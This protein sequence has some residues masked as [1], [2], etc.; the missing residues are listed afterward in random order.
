M[1][2]VENMSQKSSPELALLEAQLA[3]ESEYLAVTRCA[4]TVVA[5]TKATSSTYS[6][7]G[8]RR[9]RHKRSR[10][11]PP[12]GDGHEPLEKDDV[13]DTLEDDLSAMISECQA[14]EE[15]SRKAL[16]AEMLA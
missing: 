8:S 2:S 1:T 10:T 9:S 13:R 6:T 16:D 7:V 3:L 12:L 14:E 4:A 15:L 5:L 11:L